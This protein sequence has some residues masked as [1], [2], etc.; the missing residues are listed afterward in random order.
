MAS[1]TASP[2]RKQ[3][4]IKGFF[5]GVMTE[6]KKVHW[7]SKKQVAVYTGV[8]IVTVL[9]V[10]IAV[11]LVDGGLSFLFNLALNR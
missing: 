8:V 3:G 5:K 9:V 11:S 10:A 4:R 1:N 7:P 6:L 2:V